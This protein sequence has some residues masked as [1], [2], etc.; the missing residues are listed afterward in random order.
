MRCLRSVTMVMALSL[1]CAAAAPAA[2]AA[3]EF[4]NGLALDAGPFSFRIQCR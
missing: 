3:P 2:L 4:V 1:I